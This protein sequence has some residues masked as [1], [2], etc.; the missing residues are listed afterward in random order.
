MKFRVLGLHV[1]PALVGA[2]SRLVVRG[3]GRGI[4]PLAVQ[5]Y[6]IAPISSGR[7]GF[8]ALCRFGFAVDLT[9]KGGWVF[10]RTLHGETSGL[11][12]VP[13]VAAVVKGA[14][15][16]YFTEVINRESNPRI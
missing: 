16:A 3:A 4:I 10:S 6:V 15:G 8:V 2:A 13:A 7:V 12:K 1:N 14:M 11:K 5:S 9:G